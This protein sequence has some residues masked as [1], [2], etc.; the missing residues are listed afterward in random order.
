METSEPAKHF[1]KN[2][3]SIHTCIMVDAGSKKGHFSG[4][5]HYTGSK[6]HLFSGI[7]AYAGSKKAHFSGIRAYTGSAIFY[8][9]IDYQ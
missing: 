4:I 8:Y 7:R 2:K 9:L 3:I 5:G 6:K 1:K